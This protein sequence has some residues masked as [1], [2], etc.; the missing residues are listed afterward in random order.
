[1]SQRSMFT[2]W[3][4]VTGALILV[5]T[6]VSLDTSTGLALNQADAGSVDPS[7]PVAVAT[8]SGNEDSIVYGSLEWT[9]IE[10]R[11]VPSGDESLSR[12]V[13][14]VE[15]VARNLDGN[16]QARARRRDMALILEDG[17][18]A[19]M[20][21]FEHTPSTNRIAV[22]P[23]QVMPVTLVFKPV[24]T[25]DPWLDDLALEIAEDNRRPALLP[26]SGSPPPRVYPIPT[27]ITAIS[28]RIQIPAGR[29]VVEIALVGANVD[30]NAGPYRA[31]QDEKLIVVQVAVDGIAAT[32][33]TTSSAAVAP[34]ARRDFWQLAVGH[35]A[36]GSNDE[37]GPIQPHHVSSL[38]ALG[39]GDIG[40]T[41][42]GYELVFAVPADADLAE[43][44][45][46]A[47]SEMVKIGSI[48]AAA[49]AN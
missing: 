27:S 5:A 25:R 29:S 4:A 47:G 45:I 18:R 42:G 7:S 19:P 36:D 35:V 20:H 15:M 40:S 13:V 26:F 17:T 22:D 48:H 38:P 9:L 31:R 23:G 21:R 14:I 12:P 37:V 44:T 6:L 10:T 46:S 11:L 43:M 16:H 2:A 33:E 3:L 28:D 34:W 32:G 30:I 8:A 41:P 39:G 24:V 1:M 49:V